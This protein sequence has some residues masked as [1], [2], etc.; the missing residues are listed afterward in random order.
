MPSHVQQIV[1]LTPDNNL[2]QELR[3]RLAHAGSPARVT[4]VA[5]PAQL[6]GTGGLQD[7]LVVDLPAAGLDA[8]Q[9][10]A[11]RSW[12]GQRLVISDG[13]YKP[14]LSCLTCTADQA[15]DRLVV[16]VGG[17]IPSPN[18]LLQNRAP[19]EPP[20]SQPMR[21]TGQRLLALAAQLNQLNRRQFAESCVALLP[22]A[23]GMRLAS[24]YSF[25]PQ[26]HT[27]MLE[28]FNHPYQINELVDLGQ[29]PNQAMAWA[30]QQERACLVQD[31]PSLPA[32]V[33]SLPKRPFTHRY[34]T[35][36]C[37]IIP[38]RPRGKLAAVVNLADA[39]D[40]R[41]LPVEPLQPLL[42]PLTEVLTAALANI[43]M[44]EQ[45]QQ[46]ARTDALTGLGNYRAFAEHLKKE[47]VRSRRYGSPLSLMMLDVDGLKQVNDRHGHPAGDRLLNVMG[48]RI[49][50][51]VRETDV[52]LRC[53]G[54]EFAVILPNTALDSAR[55]VAQRVLTTIRSEPIQWRDHGLPASISVGVGQYEGQLTNEEFIRSIDTALYS[56]KLG[57]KNQMVVTTAP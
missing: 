39:L 32:A 36:S 41:P 31:W 38:L 22:P 51:A 34:S 15:A 21:F 11:V 24:Y 2:A 50:T 3:T 5:H 25:H 23:L 57:G 1:L 6:T 45:A 27:L 14:T 42:E 44:F 13:H 54:D 53:G 29:E 20:P 48:K 55:Q 28:C 52:A 4:E 9:H 40:D 16:L 10:Q 49:V 7:W 26:A 19:S 8:C 33:H 30:V 18:K 46:Q 12:P 43:G 56:A 17:G 47:V 37:L 35:R